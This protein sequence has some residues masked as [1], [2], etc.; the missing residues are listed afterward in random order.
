M[1]KKMKNQTE[2]NLPSII[3]RPVQPGDEGSSAANTTIT[4]EEMLAQK[5]TEMLNITIYSNG[6]VTEEVLLKVLRFSSNRVSEI[7][8]SKKC[9]HVTK[10]GGLHM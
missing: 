5:V 4:D 10:T 1:Q 2:K 8:Q 3:T 7:T 6:E 9:T